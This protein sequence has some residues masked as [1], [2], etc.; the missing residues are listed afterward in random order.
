MFPSVRK[1]VFRDKFQ[2]PPS[3]HPH[4]RVMSSLYFF[5]DIRALILLSSDIKIKRG[6]GEERAITKFPSHEFSIKDYACLVII[7]NLN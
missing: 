3:P 5:C 4:P 1:P 7:A 6:R 2:S